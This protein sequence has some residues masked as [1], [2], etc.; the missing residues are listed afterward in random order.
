MGDESVTL[1]TALEHG[2][3]EEEFARIQKLMGRMPNRLELGIF[4]AMWSEH[5]SYKSSRI[6]LKR[7]YTTGERVIQG[8]GENAGIIDIGGGL[9][10]VF[11]MESHNHPSYIEP[12]QGAATGVGGILRDVFT[13]GARPIAGFDS[14][15]FGDPKNER[16]AYLVKG[17]VKGISSYGNCI[18]VPTVGGSTRFHECYNGNNLVNAMTLGIV[19]NDAIFLGSAS[20]TGNK[21][22][23]IGSKTGRDG[24]HGAVMASDTFDEDSEEKRPTVQVGDPFTEKLLLEACLELFAESVVE[25]IQDM[26]AAGLTSSSFEMASRGQSGLKIH[27]DRVP[28][29]E[30]DMTPYELMLSESQERMLLVAKPENEA[31]ILEI[32]EKWDLEAEVI[33]EV[34]G[35]DRIKLFFNGTR[36]G[37]M[38]VS[39]LVDEAPMLERPVKEPE[40]LAA[41]RAF[42]PLSVP[43]PD[44]IQSVFFKLLSSPN[45]NGK[46][47][48]TEQ[49]DSMVGINTVAG[50]GSDAAVV[51]VKGTA[52]AIAVSTGCNERYCY[53]DPAT[54]GA[55]AVAEAAR[56]VACKG[57]R[58]IGATD[59]L[60]F[61][62][63]ENPEIMWQFAKAVDGITLACRELDVPIVSGNVSLYNQTGDAAIFPT[64]MIG[65]V[66]LIDDVE[67]T[68]PSFFQNEGDVIFLLGRTKS[69][70]GGSEYLKTIHGRDAGL[71]PAIDLK[72]EKTLIEILLE[73]ADKK[74]IASAHDLSEGGLAQALAECSLSGNG[75][76]CEVDVDSNM[77]GDVLL[78]SETQAR[79]L[80]TITPFAM[81]DLRPV[82]DSAK[83]RWKPVGR[84]KA[85]E[86]TVRVNG[87]PLIDTTVAE[88]EAVYHDALEKEIFGA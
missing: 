7:F 29:R 78:F 17:V 31:R 43:E 26:G 30:T 57:A 59:C 65:V 76:G 9:A 72:K 5:C 19:K 8:P 2:L 39:A 67:K 6:H 28:V 14:L 66:G 36:V 34:E 47:W 38:P 75:L 20:G 63:P 52:K 25:G 68:V 51:R 70:I 61:G 83:I 3:S 79:A 53:L 33:G 88:L 41:T 27:L 71:P 12:V 60:N 54:G 4:S 49:Y 40:Y 37:D 21:V 64:P 87:A 48:I 15:C 69:E 10:V 58:P 74:I 56:N 81:K 73:L 84:V 86:F 18:G 23:Y 32:L 55:I 11:K 77:R 42:D 80:V 22:I 50:P 45:L 1:Q 82:L 46:R 16:T 13:M 85:A 24:I 35:D 62:S 44:D